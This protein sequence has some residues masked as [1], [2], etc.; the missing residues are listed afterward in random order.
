MTN[1]KFVIAI[2]I[3]NRSKLKLIK[4]RW[5]PFFYEHHGWSNN[6]SI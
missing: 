2:K 5:S 6:R 1:Y 4:D 3:I